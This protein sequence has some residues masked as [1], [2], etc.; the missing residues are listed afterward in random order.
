[1]MWW[2]VPRPNCLGTFQHSS[3]FRELVENPKKR[4]RSPFL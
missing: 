2:K 1:M 4:G 3:T